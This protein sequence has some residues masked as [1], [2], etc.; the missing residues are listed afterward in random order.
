MKHEVELQEKKVITINDLNNKSHIGVI[1]SGKNKFYTAYVG[2]YKFA[3]LNKD[4]F[5][6]FNGQTDSMQDCLRHFV[7][8][9]PLII[10]KFD[11]RKE[12][13]QW[14]AED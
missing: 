4:G 12:L 7:D 5:T 8:N 14:L 3:L 1:T 6:T 11:T 10:Y 13:Y 2:D 9:K